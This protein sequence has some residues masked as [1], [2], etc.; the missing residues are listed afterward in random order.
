MDAPAALGF[1]H[2][3]HAVH[4][5]FELELGEHA[6]ARDIGDD[7]L[8][9]A[10]LA[11]IHADRFDLPALLGGIAFV[12]AE[13]VAREQRRFVPARPGADF[14]HGGLVVG[15]VARK[16]GDGEF[17]LRCGQALAQCGQFFF[18]HGLHLGIG[19]HLLEARDLLARGFHL[20]RHAGDRLQLGIVAA[21]LDELVA[22]QRARRHARLELGEAMGDLVETFGGYLQG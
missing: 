20:R 12:H 9:A 18:G 8:E 6:S 13:Q 4:A 15:T 16:H 19:E 5:A 1:R 14:Q 17:M 10:H 3:L 21:C 7:F 11:G 2:T 22:L